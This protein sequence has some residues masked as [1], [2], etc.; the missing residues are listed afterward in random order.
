MTDVVGQDHDSIV[1]EDLHEKLNPDV[2]V[3]SPR[4]LAQTR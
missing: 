2:S 1:L 4:S 3:Q